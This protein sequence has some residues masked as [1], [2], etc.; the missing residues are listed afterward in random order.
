ME[1]KKVTSAALR[2]MKVGQ[3][4][5]FELPKKEPY[6]SRAANSGKAIAYRL[7]RELNCKFTAV[8]DFENA[9]LTI[10][11]TSAHDRER[12]STAGISHR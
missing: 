9:V 6:L 10:T 8:T 7:Q 2:K 12:I 1:K 11:K 4:G 5:T 3:T